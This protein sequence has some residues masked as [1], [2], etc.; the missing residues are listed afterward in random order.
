MVMKTGKMGC[1]GHVARMGQVRNAC[2]ILVGINKLKPLERLG[3]R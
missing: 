1:A 3:R 2:F